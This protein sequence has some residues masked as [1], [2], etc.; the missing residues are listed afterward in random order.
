MYI[1]SEV[2]GTRPLDSRSDRE[3]AVYDLLESL[4]VSFERV[5]HDPTASVEL[6]EA[7]EKVLDIHICKNLFLSNRQGTSFYLLLMRGRKE[8]RT[9]DLSAQLGTSRL[10]FGKPEFMMTYLNTK[11]GSASVL[12]LMNDVGRQVQLVID[13]DVLDDEYIGCHPCENTT[14]LKI[15]T[16]D[17]LE[18][19]LPVVKHEA[20]LVDL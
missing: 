20:S 1:N 13:Q 3:E 18:K 9:K 11:P 16:S 14:S 7:V 19:I 2:Q 5:D 6:C 10:S 4:R 12:G 15:R 8:F 17:L